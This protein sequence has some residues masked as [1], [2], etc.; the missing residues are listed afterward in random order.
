MSPTSHGNQF[1]A[2]AATRQPG[3]SARD[4]FMAERS[5]PK[6]TATVFLSS[7][8]F[9]LAFDQL[10]LAIGKWLSPPNGNK[11]ARRASHNQPPFRHSKIIPRIGTILPTGY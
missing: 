11:I 4:G 7:P 3:V 1:E 2:D 8:P 5:K 10:L 9:S 6:W